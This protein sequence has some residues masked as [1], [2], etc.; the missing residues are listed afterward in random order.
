MNERMLGRK[1]CHRSTTLT[2]EP[3]ASLH[4]E[5]LLA[6][7]LLTELGSDK[8]HQCFAS[9]ALHDDVDSAVQRRVVMH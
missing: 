4:L 6:F 2:A 8:M 7:L 3:I 1:V 9:V 5:K